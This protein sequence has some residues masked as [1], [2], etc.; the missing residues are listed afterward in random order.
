MSFNRV[1]VTGGAGFIGRNIVKQ[2]KSSGLEVFS[3][4]HRSNLN[5]DKSINASIENY[6]EIFDAFKGVDA[7]FHEAAVTSPPEFEV[8][9]VESFAV[10]VM[11]TLNVLKASVANGVRK[12]VLASSSAVYGNIK[13]PGREDMAMPKYSNLY[14]LSK[15]FDEN[16]ALYFSQRNELE[17]VCLRYFN[18]YGAGENSKGTYSSV[19]AK[20]INDL[21]GEKTPFIY[22][23][24]TQRRDFVFVEDIARANCMALEKGK[25]GEAYNVGTGKSLTFNEIYAI[26]R[27][28]MEAKAEPRYE[29]IPYESY[30]L[31]TQADTSK[32]KRELGFQAE[33]DIKAGVK[34]MLDNQ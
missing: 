19:I 30:Q 29:P 3:L 6:S 2:C 27:D 28:E 24:G 22:G 8:H 20:F 34:K 25:S 5:A 18:T 4:D 23:D 21:K 10:N 32:A 26:V 33:V 31:Y 7:V 13:V 15:S 1:L 9:D 16:L 14:P 12:V 17:T 11:G